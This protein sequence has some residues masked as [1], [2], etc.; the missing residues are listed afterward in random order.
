MITDAILQP[1]MERLKLGP[2]A[3]AII[4]RVRA[5]PHTRAHSGPGTAQ[6][7]YASA[8][9]GM[10]IQGS[11]RV[12]YP[13]ILELEHDPSVLA[14]WDKPAPIKVPISLA[15]GK[16]HT[17]LMTPS[18]LV[19]HRD[20]VVWLEIKS[21]RELRRLVAA[22][23]GRYIAE[24]DPQSTNNGHDVGY[25]HNPYNE[26]DS[27]G[28]GEEDA[29]Y[30][31]PA[32]SVRWRCPAGEAYAAQYGMGYEVRSSAQTN[33]H[34]AANITFLERYIRAAKGNDGLPVRD[35]IASAIVN[36][37]ERRPGITVA[38]LRQQ[39]EAENKASEAEDAKVGEVADAIHI[40]LLRSDIYVD[41]RSE[42][43]SEP[44]RTH[45]YHTHHVAEAYT[46]ASNTEGPSQT[47]G[48]AGPIVVEPGAQIAINDERWL[49]V[50]TSPDVTL[51]VNDSGQQ[52]SMTQAQVTT[53]ADSGALRSLALAHADE[54][55][56]IAQEMLRAASPEDMERANWRWQVILPVVLHGEKRPTIDV[57]RGTWTRWVAGY[58]RAQ[59][60]HNCGYIGLL[61]KYNASGNR[62][63]RY[64]P[65]AMEIVQRHIREIFEAQ[66]RPTKWS[67][68]VRMKAE[69]EQQALAYPSYNAFCNEI[70]KRPLVVQVRARQGRG[71]AYRLEPPYWD[72]DYHVPRHGDRA[73]QIV[74]I[75]H[76][77]ADIVLRSTNGDYVLGRVWVTM[78][79]D[80][81]T[82]R[83]LAVYVTYD[84]PSYRSCMMVIRECVR[85]WHRLPEMLVVDNGPE[86]N[87]VYFEQLLA[88]WD[89]HKVSRPPRE[90]RYGSVMERIFLTANQQFFYALLGNTQNMKN[91]RQLWPEDRP[92]QH[93]TWTAPTLYER[94]RAWAY[95]TYDNEVHGT[96]GQSPRD[97]YNE[98][99]ARSGTQ[100]YEAIPYNMSF[101][102]STMPS[103][104]QGKAMVQT[105]GVKCNY[106]YYWSPAM[107]G[108]GVVRSI[109][110]IRYDPHNMSILYAYIKGRWVRCTSERTAEFRGRSEKEI[111][112]AAMQLREMH[113]ARGQNI[114]INSYQLA[115]FLK[116]TLVTEKLLL[117]Q[118]RDRDQHAIVEEINQPAYANPDEEDALG[119]E[120]ADTADSPYGQQRTHS[121]PGAP[122]TLLLPPGHTN[123]PF[124]HPLPPLPAPQEYD[125]YADEVDARNEVD[126]AED[127]AW[128]IEPEPSPDAGPQVGNRSQPPPAQGKK[129]AGRGTA[130]HTAARGRTKGE[131]TADNAMRPTAPGHIDISR[132]PEYEDF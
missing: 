68:W 60:E 113:K 115:I 22:A 20:R 98:S 35:D 38:D 64:E 9:M 127:A 101:L 112:L 106:V 33:W 110:P 99:M 105:R 6:A 2:T 52:L 100:G 50:S 96:I 95:E 21:E 83:V 26:P 69:C 91:P 108:A 131:S 31:P 51:L 61:P 40:M 132:L 44:E 117:Q 126:A 125:N 56:R 41:L 48:W 123:Q 13:V 54:R 124:Y 62:K 116:S 4:E 120:P 88:R 104:P 90:P 18:Y 76:T 19:I 3:R 70:K 27:E 81:Y 23:P 109:V 130:G 15:N 80:A 34:L 89:V 87:S 25:T 128:E 42:R 67:A 93:A 94:T 11:M 72:L 114:T 59:A 73:W 14:Y 55:S 7:R 16:Q 43:L 37:V 121:G 58:R 77:Q 1:I 49:V 122:G 82:R 5:R 57:P 102:R 47:Q 8:K 97:A 39:I 129:S 111:A 71:A 29:P 10:V 32:P 85:R 103:T 12:E 30:E 53:L 46:T 66:Q 28:D 92:E 84:D 78:M 45:V 17:V 107:R 63:E 118:L 36:L 86:F 65:A 79:I 119:I 74:H 24:D 75:D